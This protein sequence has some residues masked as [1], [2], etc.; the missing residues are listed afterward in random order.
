[1]LAAGRKHTSI[2]GGGGREVSRP[3]SRPRSLVG[4]TEGPAQWAPIDLRGQTSINAHDA[5]RRLG[6][7]TNTLIDIQPQM[8]RF[9]F[10]LTPAT[11]DCKIIDVGTG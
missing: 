9:T 7:P 1:M 3:Y 11:E 5:L 4:C 6:N 8:V 2:G 10:S